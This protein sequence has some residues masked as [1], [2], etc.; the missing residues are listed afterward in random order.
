MKEKV[1]RSYPSISESSL[2]LDQWQTWHVYAYAMY[3]GDWRQR[4]GFLYL[5]ELAGDKYAASGM[6][7]MLD[8]ELALK[9][10]RDN[11]EN[12][13]GDPDNVTIFGESDYPSE[14]L[15][16]DASLSEEENAHG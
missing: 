7:A 9:W 14:A 6:N 1:T 13:G 10:V 15:M 11:V 5:K 16:G 4:F 2:A 12:S 3:V 8:V